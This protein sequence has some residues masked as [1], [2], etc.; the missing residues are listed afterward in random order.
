MSTFSQFGCLVDQPTD[1][2]LRNANDPCDV[3]AALDALNTLTH[4]ADVSGQVWCCFGVESGKAIQTDAS[5]HATAA[6]FLYL[7]W[8]VGPFPARTVPTFSTSRGDPYAV[9]VRLA[10]A[11]TG[12]V[13]TSSFYLVLQ[14]GVDQSASR[15]AAQYVSSGGTLDNVLSY[16]SSSSTP[17]VLTPSPSQNTV[18]VG[19]DAYPRALFDSL[20]S[21]PG[22]DGSNNS[23]DVDIV[24]MTVDIYCT[25]NAN[26]ITPT[27]NGLYLAEYCR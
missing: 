7:L 2:L 23:E 10:G 14:A 16:S 24:A 8:S 1:N 3:A 11:S 19:L 12:G 9:R 17:A 25:T 22:K 21:W 4:C 18:K 5:P 27:L 15:A 20:V 26:G 6:G 13:G